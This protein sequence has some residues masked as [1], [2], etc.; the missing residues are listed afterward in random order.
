V[1][2]DLALLRHDSLVPVLF[3]APKRP[4]EVHVGSGLR[5]RIQARPVRR[6]QRS[7]RKG[8]SELSSRVRAS[9]SHGSSHGGS[10]L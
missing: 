5:Q 1:F 7:C 4:S 6:P 2:G 8:G 3:K 10:V 9:S